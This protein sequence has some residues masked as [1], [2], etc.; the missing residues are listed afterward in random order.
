MK[1]KNYL[2]D[3]I[4]HPDNLRLAFWKA[5]KGKRWGENVLAYQKNLDE[6]LLI[7]RSQ[8]ESGLVSVGNYQ[9]FR[10]FEPKEREI[11]ASAFDEQVLHHALMNICHEDFERFQIYDSYASRKGKGTYAA[12]AR[13]QKYAKQYDWYLK[14]DV[15]KFF[16]SIHHQVLKSQLR[17][18][19]KD[20]RLLEILNKV[21]DSYEATSN[22]GLPIG[23]L[24][25]QYFANHYLAKLD[26]I[27]KE[28]F[29]AKAYVRYMDDVVFWHNEKRQLEILFQKVQDYVKTNLLLELKPKQLNRIRHG[30]PFLGYRIYP[31]T[32]KLTQ[33]SKRRFIKKFAQLE[34]NYHSGLWDEATCQRR[35]MPLLAFISYANTQGLRESIILQSYGLSS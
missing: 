18:L 2:I 28:Q 1:R 35:A 31:H 16:A 20:L 19:Y 13:A 11:C 6:N 21:I 4:I 7:L 34:E 8:I 33:R 5:S 15:R 24:T 25:S 30:L 22:R 27:I 26:H 10:I 3:S 23:N 14:L 17:A 9:Y 29:Q 12:L 32:L